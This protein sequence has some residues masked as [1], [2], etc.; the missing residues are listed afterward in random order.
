MDGL[1]ILGAT[2]SI[3][4]SA[5]RLLSRHPHFIR[6]NLLSAH[7]RVE[8]LL[9]SIEVFRP[10]QA[11]LTGAKVGPEQQERARRAGCELSDD[12]AALKEALGNGAVDCVLLAVSGAAGLEYGL[13]ALRSGKRLAIANK[14]PLVIAGHFFKEAARA[15]RGEI[16][17]VD[18]EHSAIFQCLHGQR[19]ECISR[20]ILTTSGGPFH[21]LSRDEIKNVGAEQAL[22][23]P[24]WKMGEKITVDSATMMNKAL[25]VIEARWLFDVP[26]E[27]IEVSVHRQSI[28]HS[29]VEFD[30]G[31]VM[32]QLGVTDMQYPILYALSHPERWKAELPRLDFQNGMNLT[33][34]ALSPVLGQAI[35]FARR[36]GADPIAPIIMNAV[37]EVFVS[38]FLQGRTAFLEIYRLIPLVVEEGLKQGFTA[39]NLEEVL[40]VDRWARARALERMAR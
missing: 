34:E 28:V 16:L 31:S 3:G 6:V 10:R 24:T 30:D 40:H 2:G 11:F 21:G 19:R 17:P 32:A 37:N 5:L 13:H 35:E 12:A 20:I 38:E 7:R 15:G 8:E 18:S 14:E 36:Y 4:A 23:H 27:R 33:F 25:E 26:L 22:K 39:G 29:M 1:A 9:R